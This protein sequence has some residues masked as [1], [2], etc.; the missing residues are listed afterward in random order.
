MAPWPM[1]VV[2][3]LV[4]VARS[5]GKIA[6]QDARCKIT[7]QHMKHT[8]HVKQR[9]EP[10][11]GARD[12]NADRKRNQLCNINI[13]ASC[14]TGLYPLHVSCAAKLIITDTDLLNQ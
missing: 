12:P 11:S 13:I 7:I 14:N 8:K 6:M 4:A 10:L 3:W 2:S 1:A 9:F 5:R